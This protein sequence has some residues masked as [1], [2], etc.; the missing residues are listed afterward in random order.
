M[1]FLVIEDSDNDRYMLKRWLQDYAS[2][3]LEAS[4]MDEATLLC[5][6]NQ[7]DC[8]ILDLMLEA[9]KGVNDTLSRIQSIKHLQPDAGLIVCSGMPIADLRDMSLKAGAD[10]FLAKNPEMY[11]DNAKQIMIAVAAAMAHKPKNGRTESFMAHSRLL[12]RI[13]GLPVD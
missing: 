8:I 4:N 10:Y 6:E 11:R 1:R 13:A 9:R 12:Q 3:F 2:C 5:S 7:F